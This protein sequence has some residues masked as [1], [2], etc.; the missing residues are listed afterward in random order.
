MKAIRIAVI[1]TNKGTMKA[2]LFEEK[3]PITTTNF[4][5]LAESGFYDGLIF[6]RVI[7]KFVIQ[8]GDPKGTGTGGSAKT[9]NLEIHKDLK[10]TDGA[11]GMARSSS[12]NSAS[13]QFYICDGPQRGLDGNYAVFGQVI[14]GM[15]VVR[16]ISSVPTNAE[17]KPLD[18]VTMTKVTI[19]EQ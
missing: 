15:D 14:E 18:K 2:E 16:A 4:I 12:P 1:E 13:S 10:H 11:L 6:H 9:I 5:K 3:A 8:T 19:L 7:E 17:D